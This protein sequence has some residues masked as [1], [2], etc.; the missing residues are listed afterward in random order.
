MQFT[1][2]QDSWEVLCAGH[3]ASPASWEPV[4]VFSTLLSKLA[5]FLYHP[6]PCWSSDCYLLCTTDLLTCPK[7]IQSAA[8]LQQLVLKPGVSRQFQRVIVPL[9]MEC[10]SCSTSVRNSSKVTGDAASSA[11]CCLTPSCCHTAAEGIPA[12]P[13]TYFCCRGV[14]LVKK[15]AGGWNSPGN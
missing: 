3:G 11:S 15:L 9:L 12:F 10:W 7:T 13:M 8:I 2:S 5:L 6:A 14:S 4:L 1:L